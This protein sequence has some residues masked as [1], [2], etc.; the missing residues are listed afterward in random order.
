MCPELL[1]DI[2]YLR[3]HFPKRGDYFLAVPW[4]R[5]IEGY[6]KAE[7]GVHLHGRLI[8]IS[9]PGNGETIAR[10]FCLALKWPFGVS[11]YPH[12]PQNAPSQLHPKASEAIDTTDEMDLAVLVQVPE[13]LKSPE[14]M[15]KG[16]LPTEPRL[17][18][19]ESDY[20]LGIDTP[21]VLHASIR[22][23]FLLSTG[24]RELN[25]TPVPGKR[26]GRGRRLAKLELVR[27][28]QLPNHLIKSTAQVVSN[29]PNNHAPI[30]AGFGGSAFPDDGKLGNSDRDFK[31]PISQIADSIEIGRVLPEQSE[32]IMGQY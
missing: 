18:F 8:R 7:I 9:G 32:R 13:F 17:Q 30:E 21:K 25:S 10:D 19:F 11:L 14:M 22:P 4:G 27:K 23:D 26:V 5:V 29:I 15:R 1:Q 3:V 28:R 31:A 2:R 20:Q 16:I 24:Y 6:C 12:E